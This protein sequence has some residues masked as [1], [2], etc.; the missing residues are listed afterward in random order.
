MPEIEAGTAGMGFRP[1]L[2]LSLMAGLR[3]GFAHRRSGPRCP[4]RPW[5]PPLTAWPEV[6]QCVPRTSGMCYA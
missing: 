2:T 1:A 3:A 6:R 4:S 5:P